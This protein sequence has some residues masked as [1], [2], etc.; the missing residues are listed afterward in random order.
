M[1]KKPQSSPTV[2]KTKATAK[3]ATAKKATAKATAKKAT[4]TATAT[5]TTTAKKTP[6]PAKGTTAKGLKTAK[7]TADVDAFL[8][9]FPD[10]QEDLRC[11]EALMRTIAQAPAA[12]WGTS[13]VGF[14]GHPYTNAAGKTAS[15]P[16]LSFSPRAQNITIYIMSGFDEHDELLGR[17][18]P[19]KVGKA[20]LY[21]RRLADIDV[22]VLTTL[23]RRQAQH[24]PNTLTP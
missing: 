15:W 3:K 7:T 23:L 22:D 2:K 10:R 20:C 14:G 24:R 13:I 21:I 12:M 1:N 17:L 18:G 5:A 19:H 16:V 9:G 11:L 6:A 8:A 4:A